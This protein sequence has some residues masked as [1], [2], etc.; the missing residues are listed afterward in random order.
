VTLFRA[1]AVSALGQGSPGS[2]LWTQGT[3][4]PTG[5]AGTR[6]PDVTVV[7]DI[8]VRIGRDEARELAER[9]L[10]DPVYDDEPALFERV[11]DWVLDR[12]DDLLLG[13][14]EVSPGQWLALLALLAVLTVTG[15]VLIRGA[16]ARARRVSE[17]EAAVFPTIRS[18]AEHLVAADAAAAR[19]EWTTAVTERFRGIIRGLE[20]RQII[21]VPAGS[22]AE[23][24][25]REA[26]GMLPEQADDLLRAALLF[27]RVRYG[28]VSASYEDDAFLQAL[29]ARCARAQPRPDAV[30][31]TG[32]VAPR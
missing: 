18:A 9:E 10:A 23:E 29:A 27:D 26:G 14:A 6:T 15:G 21:D 17:A 22:T 1:T 5:A 12:L 8:P 16:R 32:L 3:P 30:L 31:S 13:A 4:D 20:E 2:N 28:G 25:S 7:P 11:V 24:V 19:G